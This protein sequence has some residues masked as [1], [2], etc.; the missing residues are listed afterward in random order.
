MLQSHAGVLLKDTGI[1]WNRTTPIPAWWIFHHCRQHYLD[2]RNVYT[3]LKTCFELSS[4]L[5][6]KRLM[7]SYVSELKAP[8]PA[9]GVTSDLLQPLASPG[10]PSAH[11]AAVQKF[12]A[13]AQRSYH[14]PQ[15]RCGLG[16]G[17]HNNLRPIPLA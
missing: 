7:R 11:T 16:L 12:M 5:R 1:K 4:I 14:K 9:L 10:A 6:Q 13:G 2:P 3:F 8:A 17:S 15:A